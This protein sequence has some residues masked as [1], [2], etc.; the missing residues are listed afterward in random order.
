[1]T[2]ESKMVCEGMCFVPSVTQQY[3]ELRMNSNTSSF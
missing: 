1:M 2:N 3:A